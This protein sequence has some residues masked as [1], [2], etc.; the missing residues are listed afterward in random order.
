M[1]KLT[2][3]QFKALEKWEKG[4]AHYTFLRVRSDVYD[5]LFTM[6]YL[7][8]RQFLVRHISDKGRAALAEYR[9]ATGANL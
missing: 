7:E 9:K 8:A 1:S 4:P 5:R 2:P 3:A 6:G